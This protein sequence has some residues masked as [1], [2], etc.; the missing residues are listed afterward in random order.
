MLWCR[1]AALALFMFFSFA[2]TTPPAVVKQ[3]D[4]IIVPETMES[5]RGALEKCREQLPGQAEWPTMYSMGMYGS[6]WVLATKGKELDLKSAPSDTEEQL[7]I[8]PRATKDE[9]VKV[10]GDGIT[11]VK[12]AVYKIYLYK[13]PQDAEKRKKKQ[14]LIFEM[15]NAASGVTRFVII[16]RPHRY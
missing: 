1:I 5:L 7:F 11:E 15:G 14:I 2:C 10:E 3:P 13:P 16:F 9:V 6:F 4:T 8:I 12:G